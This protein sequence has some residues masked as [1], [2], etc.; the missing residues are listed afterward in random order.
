MVF[1]IAEDF[2]NC[3]QSGKIAKSGHTGGRTFLQIHTF[4]IFKISIFL[5]K[6]YYKGRQKL[7]NSD[8]FPF[9]VSTCLGIA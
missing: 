5:Q 1:K 4:E 2:Q 7:S 9:Q 6:S 3:C 8:S